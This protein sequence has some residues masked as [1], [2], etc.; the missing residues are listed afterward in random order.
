MMAQ[1]VKVLD[2][3][4][5]LGSIPRT[6][7]VSHEVEGEPWPPKLSSDCH[8]APWYLHTLIPLVCNSQ[9]ILTITED[10]EAKVYRVKQEKQTGKM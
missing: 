5:N 4:D 10:L 6:H 3:P 2:K 8:Q 1:G 7:E 9:S